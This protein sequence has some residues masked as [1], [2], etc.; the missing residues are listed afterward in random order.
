MPTITYLLQDGSARVLEGRSDA[1][2][3][4]LAV[5]N[6]IAG[7]AAEC[8]G[9]LCCGTCHVYVA[10]DDLHKLPPASAMELEMLEFVA[11]ERRPQSRLSCQLVLPPG[12]ETLTVRLPDRQHPCT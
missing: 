4:E 11:A 3:M 12:L 2:V 6:G 9:A 7:I 1:S 5:E 10:D 8:G